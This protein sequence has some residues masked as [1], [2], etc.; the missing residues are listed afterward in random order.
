VSRT[1]RYRKRCGD[2]GNPT[3][4]ETNPLPKLIDPITLEPVVTPAISPFG[5]VMGLATWKV[6]FHNLSRKLFSNPT[7]SWYGVCHLNSTVCTCANKLACTLVHSMLWAFTWKVGVA[8]LCKRPAASATITVSPTL[9]ATAVMLGFW[10]AFP[11]H[12]W[13]HAAPVLSWGL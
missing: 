7:I 2:E 8:I 4:D 3:V 1:E 12:N 9:A 5:H 10:Q 6:G 13:L 11:I